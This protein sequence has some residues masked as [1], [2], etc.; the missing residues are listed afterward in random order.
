MDF[1]ADFRLDQIAAPAP[2]V[3]NAPERGADQPSFDDHVAADAEAARAM[4]ETQMREDAADAAKANDAAK[5]KGIDDLTSEK[6]RNAPQSPG[7]T[8]DIIVAPAPVTPQ[9]APAPQP[10]LQ[11]MAQ[12]TD[13]ASQAPVTPEA[14]PLEAQ[15]A[16]V[17]PASTPEPAP[18]TPNPANQILAGEQQNSTNQHEADK[19]N[20][21]KIAYATAAL[22]TPDI[23][24]QTSEPQP[25]VAPVV[26][27]AQAQPTPRP[28]QNIAQQQT[29]AV[30]NTEA[31]PQ[32]PADTAALAVNTVAPKVETTLNALA[33]EAPA[34]IDADAHKAAPK[35]E[36]P[37]SKT[38]ESQQESAPKGV[39]PPPS[40]AAA[41]QAARNANANASPGPA[42]KADADAPIASAPAPSPSSHMAAPAHQA[43][44]AG[45]TQS[46]G[47][48]SVAR[49]PQAAAQVGREIIRRFNGENTRFDFRID[50]P[51]L[52]RVDVRLEV[53][54]DHKVTAVISADSPQALTELTR[55]ARDLE[56]ALQSAGLDLA[57]NGL[58][59]DLSDQG[60][61]SSQSE[62]PERSAFPPAAEANE[63]AQ[64]TARSARPLG[65]E[66]WRGVRVDVVA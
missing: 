34:A 14:L 51:E 33:T 8:P 64:S 35:A 61:A 27:N 50:P 38:A 32:A 10:L 36:A 57:E 45:A 59:F 42:M 16:P 60:Q 17:Q 11:V 66:R 26:L 5:S 20:T 29:E 54:R 12:M 55:G 62:R 53:S 2:R 40:F 18:V 49:A 56:Q 7:E 63:E 25:A 39:A 6:P 4:S 47:E 15:T 3:N 19:S 46:A 65:M 22:E 13:A 23:A 1:G 9:P 52:G 58:R 41:L 31:A 24:A 30:V 43:A 28:T 48:Q 37:T 44:A 21:A